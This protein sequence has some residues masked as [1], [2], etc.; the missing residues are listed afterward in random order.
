MEPQANPLG[1]PEHLDV[2]FELKT[3]EIVTQDDGLEIN[4]AHGYSSL[5]RAI[6]YLLRH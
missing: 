6:K 1:A 2:P 4:P 5:L 3:V